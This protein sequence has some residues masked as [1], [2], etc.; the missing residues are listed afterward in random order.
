MSRHAVTHRPGPRQ[1]GQ[2]GRARPADGART[3]AVARSAAREDA[4]EAVF[5][6]AVEGALIDS[7]FLLIPDADHARSVATVVV[8]RTV[9]G[10]ARTK[11]ARPKA[12]AGGGMTFGTGVGL[13]VRV[14]FGSAVVVGQ[15]IATELTVRIARRGGTGPAWEGRAV[16]YQVGG[17]RGDDPATLAK[18]LSD[19][20]FRNLNGPS[21]VL[22]SVP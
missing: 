4:A 20:I 16:T 11:A 13:G 8:R 5:A 15:L 3:I 14:P 9:R 22:V 2:P 10:T 12:S 21:G 6:N 1:P 17:T 18:K 19:A 7:G